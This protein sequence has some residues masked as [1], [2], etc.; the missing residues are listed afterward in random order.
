MESCGKIVD[1]KTDEKREGEIFSKHHGRWR[2]QQQQ[3]SWETVRTDGAPETVKVEGAVFD[4]FCFVRAVFF[5]LRRSTRYSITVY[6]KL[7][8]QCLQAL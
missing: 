6:C 7:Q 4:S 3:P 8:R 1:R 5:G 2:R